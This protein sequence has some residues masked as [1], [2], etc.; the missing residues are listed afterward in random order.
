MPA[1]TQKQMSS[2]FHQPDIKL[3]A[4]IKHCSSF[5]LFC[6]VLFCTRDRTQDLGLVRE[7]IIP[8]NYLLGS[9]GRS[10]FSFV[11]FVF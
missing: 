4:N 5:L 7:V 6:F 3:N 11:S 2:V 9:D 1:R 8:L 10:L